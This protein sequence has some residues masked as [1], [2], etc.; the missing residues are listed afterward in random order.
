M[1]YKPDYIAMFLKEKK[2]PKQPKDHTWIARNNAEVFVR[3]PPKKA[4]Q[5]RASA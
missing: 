5:N 2:K 1:A 3:S 4:P